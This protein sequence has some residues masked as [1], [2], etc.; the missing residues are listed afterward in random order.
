MADARALF[1]G[2]AHDYDRPASLLSFFQYRRWHRRLVSRLDLEPN[3]IA[4]DVATG[5]GLIAEDVERAYG[6]RVTGV[7]LTPAMLA[8]ATLDR[9]A[10]ADARA[11]PFDDATFDAVT[12]SYLLRYVDDVAATLGELTRV[13]KKDGALASVE[14][15]VPRSA[16]LR[17]LWKLYTLRVM[18]LL[19]KPFGHGWPEVGAF[20]GGSIVEWD[21]AWPL[22]KQLNAWDHAGI[23]VTHVKRMSFGAG[24]VIV[25]RKR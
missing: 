7:D 11:L 20:L 22:A 14:F 16:V 19:S 9:K 17:A 25:G 1:S 23:D 24:V 2:I 4:L 10:A 13:L 21:R 12:F 8:R 3:S 6:A 5:T 18:P 15:G